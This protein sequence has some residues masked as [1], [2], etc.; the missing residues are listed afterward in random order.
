MLAVV[1]VLTVKLWLVATIVAVAAVSLA[2]ASRR[3]LRADPQLR[4]T[5]LGLAGFLL[6]GGVL[7][8]ATVGPSLLMS[9]LMFVGS[10]S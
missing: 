4:G 9:W 1:A 2:L 8:F 3:S 7:L 10:L 5:A 6:A